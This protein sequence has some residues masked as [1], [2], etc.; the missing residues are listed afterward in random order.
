MPPR[1]DGSPDI[2][3][4]SSTDYSHMAFALRL[5]EKGLFT[6]TPNPRVGCVLARNGKVVGTGWHERAGG[7]HAEV[8]ALRAAGTAARGATAYLTLEPCSHH[9]RTPPCA[10]ALVRAGIQ[11][12]VV[13]MQDPNPLVSGRGIRLL[14]EAG[15]KVQTGLREA[16]ARVLNMGFITRM[17]RKRPWVRAKVAASL[18][19]KTALANGISQWITSDAARR[20]SHRLR[21]RSCA[22]MTGIGTVLADNPRLTVRHVQTSRQPLRVVVDSRLQIPVGAALLNGNGGLIFTAKAAEGIIRSFR[23]A[24]VRVMVMPDAKGEV[25]LEQMMKTLADLGMNEVLVEGGRRLNGALLNAG[26]VDELVLYL[27]PC[28]IGDSAQGMFSMPEL[29]DLAGKRR[30]EICDV[31]TV[32]PDLRVNARILPS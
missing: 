13:A 30:L 3:M 27:A 25:D 21:A 5:A 11:R 4:F 8:Y 26:L 1:R 7:P 22:V 24:G 28:L 14:E 12:A 15:I 17:V 16:E 9:G 31:R 19:G 18:D 2:F 10:E 20:D 23:D 29:Q 6:A 32:G